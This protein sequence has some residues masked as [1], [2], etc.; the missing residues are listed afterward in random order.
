MY[1]P[2][3]IRLMDEDEF[4]LEGH[5]N[6]LSFSGIQFEL[7]EA[8]KP[9]TDVAVKIHLP[10]GFDTGPGRAVYAIGTVVWC[11][12]YHLNDLSDTVDADE[13]DVSDLSPD[14]PGPARM[15]MTF[16]LFPRAGDAD[17]L[18]RLIAGVRV[19]RA[20]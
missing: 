2:V 3:S 14:D 9:G 17:R 16:S 6:N 11:G 10:A 15:A 8:I 4:R 1:H 7:D 20:A 18:R 12:D 5:T 13:D 19:R